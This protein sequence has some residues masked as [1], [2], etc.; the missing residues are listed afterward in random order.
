MFILMHTEIVY[1]ANYIMI[2]LCLPRGL[3]CQVYIYHY[4]LMTASIFQCV[5]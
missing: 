1:V 3:L 2:N 4:I 5:R